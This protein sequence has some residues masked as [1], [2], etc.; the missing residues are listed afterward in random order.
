VRVDPD[1][2]RVTGCRDGEVQRDR[3]V[4]RRV[5]DEPDPGVR[6]GEFAGD[7]VRGIRRRPEGEDQLGGSVDL[8]LHDALH[9]AQ[10]A[11]SLR[12][13]MTKLTPA[14]GGG[15]GASRVVRARRGRALRGD[16]VHPSIMS[17]RP[18]G[19]GPATGPGRVAV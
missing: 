10:V 4:G 8:L 9:G 17:C 11:L 15:T 5:R 2:G 7:R 14:P 18:N 6:C 19:A 3:D 1:D 16:V 13:G 12:T